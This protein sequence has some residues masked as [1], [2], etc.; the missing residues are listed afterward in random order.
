LSPIGDNSIP[1]S[2]LRPMSVFIERPRGPGANEKP[3]KIDGE[4]IRAAWQ[5]AN[6]RSDG[7]PTARV[8]EEVVKEMRADPVNDT[9]DPPMEPAQA[10]DIRP[11][12]INAGMFTSATPEWYTP[13]HIIKRVLDVFGEIS[14]DPCSNSAD[15]DQANVP[16]NDY[17]TAATDGLSQPWH[18]RVYMNPPY[19]D[20]IPQWVDRMVQAF[21]GEEID[22]AIA[23]LPGRIDTN[24]F[25]PLGNYVIAVIRGRLKFSASENSAPFPSVVVYLGPDKQGFIDAFE[26]VSNFIL[27]SVHSA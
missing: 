4:A 18:G 20:E 23:L 27:Q 1:E 21:E 7:K 13:A 8:V 17:Y 15:P 24:W 6:E 25:R 5:E 11:V 22:E 12:R 10:A 3:T 14:L 16:A 9:L 26:D 2:Q 19:G